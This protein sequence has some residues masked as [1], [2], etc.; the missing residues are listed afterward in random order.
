[1]TRNMAAMA[2]VLHQCCLHTTR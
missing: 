1:M 2:S